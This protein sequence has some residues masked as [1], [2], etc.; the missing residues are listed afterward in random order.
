MLPESL[1]AYG[2][3][4]CLAISNSGAARTWGGS[5][6]PAVNMM[7]SV[8]LNFQLTRLTANAIMEA[9]EEH[10][11]DGRDGDDHRVPEVLGDAALR[12]GLD[13]VVEVEL[14]GD[15]EVAVFIG[16]GDGPQGREECPSQRD[17]PHDRHGREEDVRAVMAFWPAAGAAAPRW[18]GLRRVAVVLMP[19]FSLPKVRLR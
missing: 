8:T 12:P 9:K 17:E 10:E 2:T 5:R 16:G 7:S 1:K 6:L 14:A 19:L 13:E 3:S 11:Q 4:K 18:G 15:A